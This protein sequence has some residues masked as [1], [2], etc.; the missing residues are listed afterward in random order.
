MAQRDAPASQSMPKLQESDPQAMALAYVEDATK[1]DS[2][3]QPRYQ[4]GQLCSNCALYI[5]G[6]DPAWGGCS[7]FAGKLV[8]A[9]G[10]CSVYAP[11]P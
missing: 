7:I 5:P 10:W 9:N 3:K 8:A 11:K 2:A 1:V 6:D 4:P